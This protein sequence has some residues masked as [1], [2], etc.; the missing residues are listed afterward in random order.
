MIPPDA[1]THDSDLQG[2]GT[3]VGAL[4]LS[5]STAGPCGAPSARHMACGAPGERK[6]RPTLREHYSQ[7]ML[8]ASPSAVLFLPIRRG[9]DSICH[10][11]DPMR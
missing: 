10:E 11:T 3:A 5:G 4:Q 1:G 9:G 6:A 8:P 2:T 7:H